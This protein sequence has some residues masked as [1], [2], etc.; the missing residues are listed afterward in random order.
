M[1]TRVESNFKLTETSSNREG[2]LT[3]PKEVQ[4]SNWSGEGDLMFLLQ[5]FK[6]FYTLDCV[7]YIAS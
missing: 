3:T 2:T 4:N 5:S 1:K 7:K 6:N